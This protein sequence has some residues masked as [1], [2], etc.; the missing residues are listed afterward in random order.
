MKLAQHRTTYRDSRETKQKTL[1][2]LLTFLKT[3]F[4]QSTSNAHF[5]LLYASCMYVCVCYTQLRYLIDLIWLA[6]RVHYGLWRLCAIQMYVLLT[7]LRT[8]TTCRCEEETESDYVSVTSHHVTNQDHVTSGKRMC[9]ANA[10]YTDLEQFR[11]NSS[12]LYV[13]FRSN[14]VFDATGFEA[15]YQF[16]SPVQGTLHYCYPYMQRPLNGFIF[17]TFYVF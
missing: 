3:F 8:T 1:T 9:G 12:V 17:D 5:F 10:K 16:Y 4:S 6:H 14:D 7:Y 13:Q 2:Y 11:S 15:I